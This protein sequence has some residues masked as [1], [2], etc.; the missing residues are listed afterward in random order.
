MSTKQTAAM[1]V[2]HLEAFRTGDVDGVMQDY[3]EESAFYTPDGVLKGLEAIRRLFE[4]YL[5]GPFAPDI[6]ESFEILREDCEGEIAYVVWKA[7]TAAIEV[8][9]GSDTFIVRDGK[10]V[11][12][13]FVGH[14]IPKN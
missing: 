10:I 1:L 5:T 12:Q 3:T 7:S 6:V 2:R 8:V 11:Y 4:G 13:T 14:I 9:I